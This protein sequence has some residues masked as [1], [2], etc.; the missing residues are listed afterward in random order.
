MRPILFAL[1]FVAAGA[2]ADEAADRAAVTKTISA[3]S[4]SPHNPALF[5]ADFDGQDALHQGAMVGMC[6]E[7]WW[8]NCGDHYAYARV[9]AS[10]HLQG[11][12]GR[13]NHRNARLRGGYES[14][15]RREEDPIFNAGCGDGG[16][17]LDAPPADRVETGRDEL[18]NR[19]HSGTGRQLKYLVF[20]ANF[21]S[22][23]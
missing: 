19:I 11:A 17:R 18:E 2:W 21:A 7:V 9:A 3:L 15:H 23:M 13:S 12:L 5:T 10:H 20:S 22:P 4:L 16:C 14:S 8:E 1:I 6:P